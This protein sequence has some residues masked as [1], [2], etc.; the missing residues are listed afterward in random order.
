[1][2]KEKDERKKKSDCNIKTSKIDTFK[3]SAKLVGVP[4]KAAMTTTTYQGKHKK[5]RSPKHSIIN[6]VHNY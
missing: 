6:T 4:N 3:W 5:L 2:D 1:M